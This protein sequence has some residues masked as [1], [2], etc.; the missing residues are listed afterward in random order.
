VSDKLAGV[1]DGV[2]PVRYRIMA[3]TLVIEEVA[4]LCQVNAPD[5]NL[6]QRRAKVSHNGTRAVGNSDPQCEFER[7]ELGRESMCELLPLFWRVEDGLFPPFARSIN[8]DAHGPKIRTCSGRNVDRSHG[9]RKRPTPAAAVMDDRE[10]RSERDSGDE[11]YTGDESDQSVPVVA[12]H[13]AMVAPRL[14]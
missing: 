3:D 1:R 5:P 4:R 13:P 10:A 9:R 7:S 11:D 6:M 12:A 2:K 8:G 14:A